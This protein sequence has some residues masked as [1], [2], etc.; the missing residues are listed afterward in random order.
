M[1]PVTVGIDV[2]QIHDPTAIVVAEQITEKTGRTLV[3]EGGTPGA[4]WE[5]PETRVVYE[6]RHVQRLPLGMAYPAVAERLAEVVSR[7]EERDPQTLPWVLADATGVGRPVVEML[8]AALGSGVVLT[9]VT[10]TATERYEWGTAGTAGEIRVG[11]AFLVSRLQALLQTGSVR[12]PENDEARLLGEELRDYEIRVNQKANLVA[13]AMRAGTHDDLV[14]ALGL[15][16]LDE[17]AGRFG[18]GPRIWI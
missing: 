8:A 16:V 12:I 15:A 9:P 6:I 7:I 3:R 1:G 18:E 10:F 2:G 5:E 13:G 4:V 14:T 11:K 17:H